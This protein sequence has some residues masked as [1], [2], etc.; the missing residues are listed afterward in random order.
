MKIFIRK[1]KTN[2]YGFYNG[3]MEIEILKYLNLKTL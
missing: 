1:L 3:L 2:N